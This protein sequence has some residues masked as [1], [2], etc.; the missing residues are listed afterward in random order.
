M[1]AGHGPVVRALLR[2]RLTEASRVL[3]P[4]VPA[5]DD[6]TELLRS[7]LID[8]RAHPAEGRL[9]LLWTAVAGAYPTASQI[10]NTRRRIELADDGDLVKVFLAAALPDASYR[11]DWDHPMRIVEDSLLIDVNFCARYMHNTG[12]QRVVRRLV[13]EL[14]ALARQEPVEL[15]AWSNDGGAHRTLSPVERLRV[16]DWDNVGGVDPGPDLNEREL[17]VPWRSRLLL[18]DVGERALMSR[19]VALAEY[20]GNWVDVIGYD[21]IPIVSADMV[22][23]DE[24]ERGAHYLSMVKHSNRVFAIS[25]SAAKEF[26][27]FTS[28]LASQGLI[29]PQ[30]ESIPLP[31]GAMP[32]V[33][34]D[35]PLA[36][37][38]LVLCVGSHEPRKNQ[39]ALLF[40]AESL[41]REGLTFRIVFVGGGSKQNILAFDR[42]VQR[43]R[44]KFGFD[45][46]SVRGL[47]DAELW[48]L[49]DE[50]RFTA[51]LSLHEGFG[52]PVAESLALGTPVL[53]SN[54]GSLA[55]IAREGGCVM[56]D[57]R[58]DDAIIEGMRAMLTDDALIRR[59]RAEIGKAPS[60]TWADYA[61]DIWH[62]VEAGA[63]A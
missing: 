21:L 7:L 62:R 28:A 43:L 36:E 18:P 34:V 47:G 20:S 25:D 16:I 30:V 27:G 52:L 59:L 57:P 42:R 24:S 6:L 63:T 50:A 13:P 54:Y 60:R 55:E 37:V 51:L 23:G 48:R 40:A 12:I 3:Q 22:D 14:L 4:D 15:V 56:V 41:L 39:D 9:W 38:P 44:R 5:S 58:D 2:Q 53:T 26:T 49:F 29:G 17:V 35:A 19:L 46:E 33:D 1:A 32:Q 11:G 45:I 10:E 8:V 61:A 31:T